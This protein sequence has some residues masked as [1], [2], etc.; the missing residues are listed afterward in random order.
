MR[1]KTERNRAIYET[2]LQG[3]ES[4]K[5]IGARYGIGRERVRQICAKEATKERI[6]QR[7]LASGASG[8]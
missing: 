7:K 4:L 5:Q 3:G 6:R 1:E 2:W 8:G